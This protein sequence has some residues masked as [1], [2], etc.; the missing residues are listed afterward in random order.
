[1]GGL[2][3]SWWAQTA[4]LRPPAGQQVP[5]V[6][7]EG[8]PPFL[9]LHRTPH[10]HVHMSSRGMPRLACQLAK[11]C[12]HVT[13][14][15]RGWRD[16]PQQ[17]CPTCEGHFCTEAD[18]QGS[19]CYAEHFKIQQY[20]SG[21]H[22]KT[23]YGGR[24][25]C[26][27]F[28]SKL[29]R[30]SGPPISGQARRGEQVGFVGAPRMAVNRGGRLVNPAL[31]STPC[32]APAAAS[33]ARRRSPRPVSHPPPGARCVAGL[34]RCP[35]AGADGPGCTFWVH[36]LGADQPQPRRRRSPSACFSAHDQAHP[37][38]CLHLC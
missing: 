34:A 18:A 38:P 35:C 14:Q 23:R 4:D 15:R 7:S 37:R 28:Q 30:S 33:G 24:T 21:G 32:R 16:G 26:A 8:R 9:S 36:F 27:F 3:T 2:L 20:V 11:C 10:E 29:G 25:A 12:L 17:T 22:T 6:R 13:P 1:M 31:P 5:V 19:T